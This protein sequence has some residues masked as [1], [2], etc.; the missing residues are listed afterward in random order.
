VALLWPG[1][2]TGVTRAAA[3]QPG[4]A[5]QRG[6]VQSAV[7]RSRFSPLPSHVYAP[8][9]ETYLRPPAVSIPAIARQSGV[10]YFT[11]AF[12]ESTGRHS[13]TLGWNGD[14]ARPP[15]Y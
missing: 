1:G 13:C 14:L 12:L 9:Y 15:A 10:R 4:R 7:T 3:A 5:A 11:L 8:Y 6:A 2:G